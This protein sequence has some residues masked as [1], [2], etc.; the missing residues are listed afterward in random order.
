MR[1]LCELRLLQLLINT[2][3]YP[4][5]TH[6]QVEGDPTGGK[7][8]NE[9]GVLGGAPNKLRITNNFHVSCVEGGKAGGGLRRQVLRASRTGWGGAGFPANLLLAPRLPLLDHRSATR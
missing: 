1:L 4:P 3:P 2:P 7:Y 8:S 9:T 5:P 6:T